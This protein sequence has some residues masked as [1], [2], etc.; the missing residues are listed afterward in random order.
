MRKMTQIHL[1]L[2]GVLLASVVSAERYSVTEDS[3][4]GFS[5]EPVDEVKLKNEEASISNAILNKETSA[6]KAIPLQS[7]SKSNPLKTAVEV[8]SEK[9]I[10]GANEVLSKVSET[11][12]AE[13][14]P[15]RKI[16]PFEKAYLESERKAKAEVLKNFSA[17]KQRGESP[18]TFDATEIDPTQFMDGDE[19]ERTGAR[20][21]VEKA[22]YF[23]T[24][25][26]D[27]NPQTTFYDPVLVS[28]VM[29]KQRNKKLEYTQT[30]VY[31]KFSHNGAGKLDL[32]EGAD[33]IAVQ[34]LSSGKKEF[35]LFFEAFSKQCCELLP[36]IVTPAVEMGR[37]R[38]FQLTNEDLYYR[39]S[40]GDSR[41]L[42][43]S[44]PA[45][46]DVNYPLRIRSFI[47]TFKK[48]SVDHGV[49]F[50]QIVTLDADKKPVRIMT[51]PVLKYEA[52]TWSTH[53]YLEGLFLIDR[54]EQKDER[55]VLINTTRNV[56]RQSSIIDSDDPIKID[57]MPIG[58]FEIT[59]I[60]EE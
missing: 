26:T 37:P 42:L 45:D 30:R 43:I 8:K 35:D 13:K 32:P 3:F 21:E 10:S 2:L 33:P 55:F 14:K 48:L 38:A 18:G 24:V 22:P 60:L 6:D 5:A 52:E 40:E 16:S 4:G 57:H 51:G 41:F 36:N 28:D 12:R 53:G 46:T 25:D 34:L 17:N 27:G 49:F 50:P 15:K 1:L 58:S 29:D 23:I 7:V 59:A 11:Q 44:L 56:L 47:R 39:F 9:K 54:S 20:E 31:E 19:L